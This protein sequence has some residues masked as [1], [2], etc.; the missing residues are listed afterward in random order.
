MTDEASIQVDAYLDRLLAQVRHAPSG[1]PADPDLD[2]AV[3]AVASLLRSRLVRFHPSFRFEERLAA[4]LRTDAG[5]RPSQDQADA[6]GELV[7]FPGSFEAPGGTERRGRG[8]LVGG[9]I[10]S[11]V[12]SIASLAGAALLAWRRAR[13]DERWERTL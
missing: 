5:V 2:P 12:V 8:L 9:A 6:H 11:G 7:A 13:G 10:A 1:V 4:R 3:V